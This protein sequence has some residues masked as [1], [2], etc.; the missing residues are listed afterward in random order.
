MNDDQEKGKYKDRKA[1]YLQLL[2]YKDDLGNPLLLIGNLNRFEIGLD[3]D[4]WLA[5]LAKRG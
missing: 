1:A 3:R 4:A 2:N 5:S